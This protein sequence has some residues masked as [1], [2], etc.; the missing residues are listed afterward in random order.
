M[1]SQPPKNKDYLH[2]DLY[3]QALKFINFETEIGI[4]GGEPSLFKNELFE[5]YRY[6][7]WSNLT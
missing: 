1:C 5:F 3:R 7:Q 4:S 6:Y 2:F